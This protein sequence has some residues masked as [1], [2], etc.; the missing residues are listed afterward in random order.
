MWS[1]GALYYLPPHKRNQCRTCRHQATIAAGTIVVATKL[2]R[3]LRI[4]NQSAVYGGGSIDEA[5]LPFYVKLSS[6]STF[7][8]AAIADWSQVDLTPGCHVISD[9]LPCF[10]AVAEVG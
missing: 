10:S 6:V 8:F 1:E 9:G 4:K 5:G 7:S 3:R 2:P